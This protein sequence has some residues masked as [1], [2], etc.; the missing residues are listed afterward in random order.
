VHHARLVVGRRSSPDRPLVKAVVALLAEA[1]VVTS[2]QGVVLEVNDA[3]C[4]LAGF[5]RE[6][7]LGHMVPLLGGIPSATGTDLRE[8]AAPANWMASL[9]VVCADGTQTNLVASITQVEPDG[10]GSGTLL[11]SVPRQLRTPTATHSNPHVRSEIE[12]AAER[13]EF[14]ARYQP[15][16][17]LRH[18]HIEAFEALL[19]WHH[20]VHGVVGPGAF[21][22]EAES[23]CVL[24]DITRMIVHD[25][26]RDAAHW[27]GIRPGG[28]PIS[29]SVNLCGSQLRDPR[30]IDSIADALTTSKLAPSLLWLEIAENTGIT[31]AARDPE[32]LHDLRRIGSK[33]VLDGFGI[34]YASLGSVRSLPLDILKFD[35]S[36]VAGAAENRCDARILAAGIEMGQALE[37]DVI[38]EGIENRAQLEYLRTLEC[39]SG[40]GSYFSRPID[41]ERADLLVATAPN[42]LDDAMSWLAYVHTIAPKPV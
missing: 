34:G 42:W 38:A 29:V 9:A 6:A 2:A 33:L 11:I 21:I 39:A 13:R 20:P 10:D 24:S 3:F 32:L 7:L 35:R 12:L 16:V 40:Q 8:V 30:L 27:N 28:L 15:I 26:C 25:A 18:G 1:A 4:R 22:G 5:R 41:R 14:F 37:I 23:R 36:L 19:R 31:E 17:S